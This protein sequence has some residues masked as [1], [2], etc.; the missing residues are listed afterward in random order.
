MTLKKEKKE[1][2]SI[3]YPQSNDGPFFWENFDI[4]EVHKIEHFEENQPQ[5]GIR[6]DKEGK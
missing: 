4:L 1:E 5:F 6:G 2:S 3:Y